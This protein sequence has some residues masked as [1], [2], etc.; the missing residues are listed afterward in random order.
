MAA[1][2]APRK[3]CNN[4]QRRPPVQGLDVPAGLDTGGVNSRIAASDHRRTDDSQ[5]R[6]REDNLRGPQGIFSC[7]KTTMMQSPHLAAFAGAGLLAGILASPTVMA[8]KVDAAL[9]NAGREQ[10]VAAAREGKLQPAIAQLRHLASISADRAVAF[11][12][13]VVLTWDGQPEEALRIYQQRGLAADAPDYVES[14]VA[15]AY[16]AMRRF[17]E[18]ERMAR[19]ALQKHPADA[20]WTAFLALVL[21]DLDRAAEAQTVLQELL[22][23]D[24]GNAQA[25]RARAY[26]ATTLRDPFAALRAY[27]EANRLQPG[28]TETERAL[29]DI[30]Q[31]L[32]APFAAGT[33]GGGVTAPL[34][35]RVRQAASRVRWGATIISVKEAERF[36]G[37]DAAI[38]NLD[39]LIT[40]ATAATPSD[41]RLLRILQFDR[42]VALR[43]RERWTESLA[44]I[45]AL[46]SAGGAIPNYVRLAQADALLAMRRPEEA[47]RAYQ[48]VIDADPQERNAR[49]GRFYAEVEAEDFAAAFATVDALAAE[50]GPR[51]NT[52]WRSSPEPNGDWL[53][54]QILA[55]NAR[56]Y[57]DMNAE[58]WS[59]IELLAD[60]AP[61]LG[62]LR[63]A[64]GAIAAARGWPRLA[65]QE[66]YI[67]ASLAPEDR[68]TGV[69][70]ADSDLRRRDLPSARRSTSS[71]IAR[72]PNDQAVLRLARDLALF[73]K[74]EFRFDVTSRREYGSASAAPGGG[75]ETAGRVYSPPLAERWRAVAA[76][77]DATAVP[78]EGWID[79]KRRGAGIE[80]AG[81]DLTLEAIAWQNRG[82]LSRNSIGLTGAWNTND[83]WTVYAGAQTFAASTPLRAL[84]YGITSNATDLGVQ[85]RWHESRSVAGAVQMSKF[86]DGNQRQNQTVTF[87]QR[88]VDQP[89][90]DLTLRPAYYASRNSRLG[91]PY[92]NPAKDQALTLALDATHV[93]ARFYERS[94]TQQLI[95]SAGNYAQQGYASAPVGSLRYE[96][97]H[98]F[99]PS[100]EL[101]YGIETGRQ[102]YDGVPE[103][104]LSGF[105]GINKRF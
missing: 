13:V 9:I 104:T 6:V 68:G 51:R 100:I 22:A 15:R 84:F 88:I 92:F 58:A 83:H 70:L 18:A 73:D 25:W 12:L 21:T 3:V 26:A 76:A 95:V 54:A 99:D 29:A 32:G 44:L 17:A 74:A 38:T 61:A 10:A 67:A 48:D 77:D 82:T 75:S 34:A 80:Y 24:P 102:V 97:R 43:N 103:R 72:F 71:L 45:D 62:Y 66:I 41:T 2:D 23:R 86:S 37:T 89:H 46:L 30:L 79:R 47:R 39:A 94:W 63:A 65:E 57:A 36:A 1:G 40:E 49:I 60:N 4:T 56:N 42:T 50:G 52:P 14:A 59:K 101:R 33:S 81:P 69:A 16:R 53:E 105:F 93:I 98:Q 20:D 7:P 35:I 91:A 96:Q 11:D 85:Y 64:R 55:A 27:G 5:L 31:T 28:N 78:V 87:S 90:F 19:T 8:Q